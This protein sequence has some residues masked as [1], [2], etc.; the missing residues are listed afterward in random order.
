MW[1]N[2]NTLRYWFTV[3]ALMY[4]DIP[5]PGRRKSFTLRY[6]DP[7][8]WLNPNSLGVSDNFK[9]FVY[10]GLVQKKVLEAELFELYRSEADTQKYDGNHSRNAKGKTFL[11]AIEV[12]GSGEPLLKTLQ[13]AAFSTAFAGRK[14][15]KHIDYADTLDSLRTKAEELLK[16]SAIGKADTQWLEQVTEYLIEDLDWRPR[17]LMAREQVYIL[18]VPLTGK[19]GKPLSKIPEMDPINSFYLEDIKRVLA[20]TANGRGV[21]Q[22]EKYLNG[23]QIEPRKIDVTQDEVI[24]DLLAPQKFPVG[25]WPSKFPLFLMQQVAVNT[26]LSTLEKDGLFS[27]NGPP[28]TGKTTL[29]MDIIAARIVERAKVLVEFENPGRAFSQS[30]NK[31]SYPPNA[32][33]ATYQGSCYHVDERLLDF[34]I[35]VASA[36]NKAVENITLDLPSVDKVH[37]Q[38]LVLDD[39]TFEYFAAAAEAILNPDKISGTAQ[40]NEEDEANL[41]DSEVECEEHG[42]VECW[43]L[44]SVPLGKKQNRNLVA[45]YLGAFSETSVAKALENEQPDDLDWETIRKQFLTAVEDVRTIQ[46]KIA[47]FDSDFK[48]LQAAMDDLKTAQEQAANA[49][50]ACETAQKESRRLGE[51]CALLE[52]DFGSNLAERTQYSK[53]WP[54]W[55]VLCSKLFNRHQYLAFQQHRKE[56]AQEYDD[57]RVKRA[58][59][60]KLLA[61]ADNK[62]RETFAAKSAAAAALTAHEKAIER[63]NSDLAKLAAELGEAAFDPHRFRNLSSDKREKILPRSNK[64]YHVLRAQV[65]LAAMQ[66]H[67]AFAKA[68]GKSFETNFRLALAMLEQ[69][70][71]LQP[72][73]PKMAPHLWATFFL[74][75][76][77]VSSTF[78]SFSRCFRDL[79]REQIGLLLVDESGQAVPSHALGAI[80]RSKRALLVGDPLQ[81]EP[82]M[83]MDRKLDAAILKYH[84]AQEDHQLTQYSAQHLADRANV[85]GA[86]VR[87]YDGEDLWIGAPLRVHRRCVDPMFSV[88]NSIAYN[89]KMVFGPEPEEEIKA[90]AERPLL[91]PSRWIHVVSTEF[92]EHYSKAE[93]KAAAELVIDF[94]KHGLLSNRDNLPDLFVISPFKS[95]ADRITDL[96]SD[97]ANEWAPQADEEKIDNWLKSHVGTVHTFQGKESEAVIFVLGGSTGGAREW[98]A[99][100]PNI[101]NVAVTRAKRRLYVIGNRSLWEKTRFGEELSKALPRI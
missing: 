62:T 69:Q 32:S 40:A 8:P 54:W 90:A 6:A 41:Q 79:G 101:I 95:V 99:N 37:P 20:D 9:Y 51:D 91:G 86:Y 10:F 25:R 47:Q 57:L 49:V 92:D 67:K 84:K 56:L 3:E 7:L 2:A 71:F 68:A 52:Q 33:G 81:V 24:N 87:Q 73:L 21:A 83:P 39:K 75:V 4:P 76:P 97:R 22:V 45:K 30:P 16:S 82:V 17:E 93:G 58:G 12:S 72:C 36:N 65:F 18:Q 70:A 43:G 26:A 96:L 28:G 98:A 35:V 46:L 23:E 34:A 1:N 55:R 85:Y 19:N 80:W 77:V 63:L 100:R 13:L 60:K 94:H 48:T 74:V 88:S 66:L 53:D 11:G 5:K 29:L 14:N 59:N 61:V 64:K 89:N 27:V 38:P 42:K 44:I 50:A 78:A 31:F 15:Q